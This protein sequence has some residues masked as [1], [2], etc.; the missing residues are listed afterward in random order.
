MFRR[1]RFPEIR[2]PT[3]RRV[4]ERLASATGPRCFGGGGVLSRPAAEP[5]ETVPWH[6]G[7]LT[8]GWAGRS[9]RRNGMADHGVIPL[10]TFAKGAPCSPGGQSPYSPSSSLSAP[11]ARPR[12]PP[13]AS[14]R[15]SRRAIR[16]WRRHGRPPSQFQQ[17]LGRR[18]RPRRSDQHRRR[19]P[20]PDPHRRSVRP[21]RLK[22]GTS[23]ANFARMPGS[24][25]PHD[26]P[27]SLRAPTP[28]SSAACTPRWSTASASTACRKAAPSPPSERILPDSRK[29]A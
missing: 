4:G 9:L 21:S 28:A 2:T 17:S 24:T 29:Q 7:P 22:S 11:V 26:G 23:S 20:R 16:P 25:A 13:R 18:S 10:P 14:A 3:S 19:L 27:A 1:R 5:F 6:G 15:A 12:R 8:C